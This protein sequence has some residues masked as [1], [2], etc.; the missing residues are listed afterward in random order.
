[1]KS[2]SP[3]RGGQHGAD[4]VDT[5]GEAIR[6]VPKELVRNQWQPNGLVALSQV[7]APTPV[8][9]LRDGKGRGQG[10]LA[11]YLSK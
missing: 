10:R 3:R 7:H 9:A 5:G 2:N 11:D 8:Q 4:L 6:R 1:M